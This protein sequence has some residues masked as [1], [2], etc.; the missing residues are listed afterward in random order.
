[1]QLH[2]SVAQHLS[3]VLS[4]V[5]GFRLR[6]QLMWQVCDVAAWRFA[7]ETGSGRDRKQKPPF[8]ITLLLHTELSLLGLIRQQRLLFV[9]KTHTA[10]MESNTPPPRPSACMMHSG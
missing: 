8:L 5:H 6:M 4:S 7:G 10:N 2:A 1:M 9:L 3:G